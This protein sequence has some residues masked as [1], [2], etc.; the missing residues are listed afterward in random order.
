MQRG[1]ASATLGRNPQ[2]IAKDERTAALGSRL[3]STQGSGLGR[4]EWEWA[5]HL[6]EQKNIRRSRRDSEAG[7]DGQADSDGMPAWADA[8]DLVDI[9]DEQG[10][11]ESVV[12]PSQIADGVEKSLRDADRV[13]PGEVEEGDDEFVGQMRRDDVH[14]PPPGVDPREWNDPLDSVAPE[15]IGSARSARS[16]REEQEFYHR[17]SKDKGDAIYA[18]FEPE[19]SEGWPDEEKIPRQMPLW[20]FYEAARSELESDMELDDAQRSKSKIVRS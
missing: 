6:E 1:M 18:G 7:Q 13:P 8:M 12:D 2:T 15:K 3:F 20:M 14:D 17:M 16:T 5:S 4:E 10:N 19:D 9:E 11:I